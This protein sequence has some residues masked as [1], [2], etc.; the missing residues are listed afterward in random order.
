MN[1]RVFVRW[2]KEVV[3]GEVVQRNDMFGMTAVR[4]PIQ[5]VKTV[6][7]F[8]PEH[9]YAS[10]Q[11]VGECKATHVVQT[12]TAVEQNP[13]PKEPSE[14][15]KRLQEFKKEHW[16]RENN[17]LQLEY[18]PEHDRMWREAIVEKLGYQEKQI[19]RAAAVI[20]PTAPEPIKKKTEVKQLTLEF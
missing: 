9:V 12:K 17:R 10:L 11:A 14:A 13:Q 19:V 15:W 1:E 16:D 18:W 5:G 8:H 2:Y 7:L 4:I 6:A 20:N 3:E